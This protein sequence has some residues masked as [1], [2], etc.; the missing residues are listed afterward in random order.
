[1]RPP[2]PFTVL[3][4]ALL[5]GAASACGGGA[6]TDE[7][8]SATASASASQDA[9]PAGTGAPAR[10]TSAKDYD[11][12]LFDDTSHIVD[13]EWFPLVP[14][15]HYVW[16]GRAFDDEGQRID[17]RVQF[18]VTDLTKMIGGVRAVVGWDRD[19]NDGSMG[20]S[21][22][23]FY[24]QDA[25][26]NVWHLGELVEHWDGGELDGA[27]AWFVDSPE[28]ARAGVQMLAEPMVG[29]RYSQGFAP[30]PWYWDDRARVSDVGVRTCVP[31]DCFDNAI[32]TEE[33]EP[34]FPGSFQL[35]YFAS[36]VGGI[37]VGWRGDDE[38]QE[39]MVLTS[40]EQLSPE[41]LAKV[42]ARVLAQEARAY[43]YTQTE[44]AAQRTDLP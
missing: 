12:S 22:L 40:F 30:P 21:E 25:A 16:E 24:A 2:R 31:V 17:R 7:S 39:V 18:I 4:L 10:L 14:G 13:N 35:K 34:R 9:S 43:A 26:G 32:I 15:T 1:M 29:D 11:P 38:E 23:I 41:A 42:R 5:L 36:G 37:R 44:P 8:S 19:F 33:F 6:G 27:R 3:F 28:G 20:E